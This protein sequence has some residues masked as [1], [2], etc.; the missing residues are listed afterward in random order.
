MRYTLHLSS[1]T[2]DR[3]CVTVMEPRYRVEFPVVAGA[4]Y[5]HKQKYAYCTS[6]YSDATAHDGGGM[7]GFSLLEFC[8]SFQLTA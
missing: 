3:E 5:G 1:N 7:C 8:S 2:V 6:L 4:A